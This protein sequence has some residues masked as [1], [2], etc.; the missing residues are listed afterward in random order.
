[1]IQ[2]IP[3]IDLRDG[4]VV[5][6]IQGDYARQVSYSCTPADA[7]RHWRDLGAELIHV[8]DL[9]GAR[10]GKP[11]ES[12]LRALEAIVGATDAAIEWGGGIRNAMSARRAL[13]AGASRVVLGTAAACDSDAAASM[14][15]ELAGR[16]VIG[17]DARD[18]RVA[19][20]GWTQ[21]LDLTAE[22]LARRMRAMGAQRFIYT[23]IAQDGMLTGPNTAAL[24]AFCAAVDAPVIASGGVA[25]ASHISALAAQ[26]LPNL[27]GAIVGKAL[28]DGATD[29]AGLVAAAGPPQGSPQ[30]VSNA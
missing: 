1:M 16:V 6:L 21:V 14:L 13:E 5:R 3:A 19:V 11:Q 7:A 17:I 18:G 22:D 12:S 10:L 29:Y 15:S 4:A 20:K 27:E 8:V 9:D 24:R 26:A 25:S 30:E 23:D 28:Y 2:I